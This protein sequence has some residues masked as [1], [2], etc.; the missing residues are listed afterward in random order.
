V[1]QRLRKRSCR[2]HF[3]FAVIISIPQ[4]YPLTTICSFNVSALLA[5]CFVICTLP[6]TGRGEPRSQHTFSFVLS[7]SPSLVCAE[8]ATTQTP[9]IQ[10]ERYYRC[11]RSH[12]QP[13][14]PASAE[15]HGCGRPFRRRAPLRDASW[16]RL[17]SIAGSG[18]FR[19]PIRCCAWAM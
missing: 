13:T 11:S 2:G 14:L 5:L 18:V 19:S 9:H 17:C 16:A 15:W 12:T 4:C 10:A 1:I 6:D 3:P 7:T 8:M